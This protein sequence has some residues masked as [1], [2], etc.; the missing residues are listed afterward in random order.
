MK[1]WYTHLYWLAAKDTDE[2]HSGRRGASTPR[3]RA[4]SDVK[5]KLKTEKQITQTGEC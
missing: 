2:E 4:L 5:A 3:P 1:Q